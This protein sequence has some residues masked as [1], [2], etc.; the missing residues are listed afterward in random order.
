MANIEQEVMTDQDGSG[1]K[2]TAQDGS[3]IVKKKVNCSRWNQEQNDSP[4]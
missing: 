1:I 2:M 4:R 3:G